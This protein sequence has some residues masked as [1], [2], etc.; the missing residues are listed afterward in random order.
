MIILLFLHLHINY[1]YYTYTSFTVY[2]E[3]KSSHKHLFSLLKNPIFPQTLGNKNP[4]PVEGFFEKF[5]FFIICS[6]LI[7]LILGL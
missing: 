5:P 6:H 1:Y 2:S 7:F 3:I 4:G